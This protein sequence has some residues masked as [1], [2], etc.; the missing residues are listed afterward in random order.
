MDTP[1]HKLGVRARQVTLEMQR[2]FTNLPSIRRN[3]NPNWSST[4]LQIH[5]HIRA[6]NLF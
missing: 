5:A 2:Q 4:I 3:I 1:K 6:W